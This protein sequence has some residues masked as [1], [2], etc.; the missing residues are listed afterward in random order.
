MTSFISIA[1]VSGEVR[2]PPSGQPHT[3][4][5]GDAVSYQVGGKAAHLHLLKLFLAVEPETCS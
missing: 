4:C 1:G 5:S 2:L 3:Q